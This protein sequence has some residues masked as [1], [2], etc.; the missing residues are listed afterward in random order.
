MSKLESEIQETITSLEKMKPPQRVVQ[1][2]FD[3]SEKNPINKIGADLKDKKEIG[4]MEGEYTKLIRAFGE[5]KLHFENAAKAILEGNC[6]DTSKEKFEERA[7]HYY[8]ALQVVS[9]CQLH[10]AEQM[11]IQQKRTIMI[12]VETLHEKLK[13]DIDSYHNTVESVALEVA[14]HQLRNINKGEKVSLDEVIPHIKAVY[15]RAYHDAHNPFW[16]WI[17]NRFIKSDRTKEIEFLNQISKHP[18]C[19]ESIRLQAIRLV[20]DKIIKTEMFGKEG[21][22]Y[23]GSK[24]GKLLERVI[25]NKNVEKDKDETLV[26]FINKNDLN[27]AIPDGLKDYLAKTYLEYGKSI[28]AGNQ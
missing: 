22:I 7:M 5:I 18:Q 20:H 23:K 14:D 10:I 1:Q 28:T 6:T 24:L 19:N 11:R 17:K 12:R 15:D 21:K 25:E 9:G 3:S 2:F 27:D 26:D 13:K 16:R 4:E 8:T